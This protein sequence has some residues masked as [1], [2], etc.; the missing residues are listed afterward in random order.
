VLSLCSI[1]RTAISEE[2]TVPKH[3]CGL[4]GLPVKVRTSSYPDCCISRLG[5]GPVQGFQCQKSGK[6][7]FSKLLYRDLPHESQA[8][9][10]RSGAMGF[11]KESYQQYIST[12]SIKTLVAS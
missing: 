11:G 2:H 12:L 3:V 5:V 7:G 9:G 4:R 6:G 8:V 10:F 1:E